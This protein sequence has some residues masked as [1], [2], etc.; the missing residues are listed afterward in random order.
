MEHAH[1][2]GIV[3]RD[4]KPTNVIVEKDD[5]GKYKVKIIDFGIALQIAETHGRES[6]TTANS[7]LG[8][9]LYM[10]PEQAKGTE[11]DQQSDIYSLGIIL[12]ECLTG[13][14]PFRGKNAL[15]TLAL[16]QSQRAPSLSSVANETFDEDLEIVVS[17]CLELDR[18][19]R[20]QKMQ[21]LISDIEEVITK[22][23]TDE[24]ARANKGKEENSVV[25]AFVGSVNP[26]HQNTGSRVLV[27]LLT[28]VIFIGL[29]ILTFNYMTM[30]EKVVQIEKKEFKPFDKSKKLNEREIEA[31]I[32]QIESQI[33]NGNERYQLRF[34][35]IDK[36]ALKLIVQ[37]PKD[38]LNLFGCEFEDTR[39]LSL[40]KDTNCFQIGA[41]SSNLDDAGT[42][43]LMTLKKLNSL[44]ANNTAITLKGIKAI[45]QNKNISLLE[46]DDVVNNEGL[47][48][49][50]T[51]P[52]LRSLHINHCQ[53]TDKGLDFLS[54]CKS[55][56]VLEV[57]ECE[58]ITKEGINKLKRSL[59]D[60]RIRTSLK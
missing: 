42:S 31:T 50:S 57:Q 48:Y 49:L 5:N 47:K 55:L 40:L 58:S 51:L 22:L 29:G 35:L 25:T 45:S 60:C 36:S 27:F 20:Y 41:S 33:A 21:A 9:P 4:L 7:I 11:V 23:S 54:N 52:Q 38:I 26:V 17:S 1:T 37:N 6:V 46:L 53:I 34:R 10:S 28:A 8:S 12:F 43:A 44:K 3:H 56:R 39:D 30:K 16:K 13:K 19:N 59:P 15:D 18:A 14:L 2:I 24:E 32:S